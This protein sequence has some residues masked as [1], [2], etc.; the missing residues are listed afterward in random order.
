MGYHL[1]KKFLEFSL[2]RQF[3]RLDNAIKEGKVE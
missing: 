1:P 3:L 2:I